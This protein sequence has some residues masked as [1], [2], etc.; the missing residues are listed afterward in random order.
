MRQD[1]EKGR[2]IRER[3]LIG[4]GVRA[5]SMRYS[6]VPHYGLNITLLLLNGGIRYGMVWLHAS[7]LAV[8]CNLGMRL[9]GARLRTVEKAV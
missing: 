1:Q 2:E 7:V 5:K 8:T 3:Y 6:T 9:Q 4:Q